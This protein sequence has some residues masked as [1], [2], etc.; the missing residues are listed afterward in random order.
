MPYRTGFLCWVFSL[1]F[2]SSLWGRAEFHLGGP[3]GM[4]WEDLLTPGRE[5]R[6]VV[7]D[8]DGNILE[9]LPLTVIGEQASGSYLSDY[10]YR[11]PDLPSMA[12]NILQPPLIDPE[13]NLARDSLLLARGGHLLT[14]GRAIQNSPPM[15]KMIDGDLT[16]ALLRQVVE[17]PQLAG[18][19]KSNVQAAT[20]NLGAELPINRIR[21][22]PR[23]GFEANY[24]KWY[25][26]GVADND[27]PYREAPFASRPGQVFYKPFTDNRGAN[28]FEPP[29]SVLTILVDEREN[30]D[31]DEDLRFP[32]RDIRFISLRPL[33][34]ERDWEIAE[35]EVY[36][37][38]YMQRTVYRSHIIDF[39]Q[40]VAWSKIRWQGEAPPGTQVLLRTRTGETRQ[41]SLFWEIGVTGQFERTVAKVYEDL[42]DG[43]RFDRVQR[44]HDAENW[45]FWSATYDFAAGLRNPE[46]P[47]EAWADGTLLLSPSPGRYLQFEIV[48][49]ASRDQAPR[50]E[51]LSL[52]LAETPAVEEVIGEI[53]P[54]EVENFGTHA[55][56]YVVKPG[57]RVGNR[58]FD[59][60]EIST[61]GEVEAVHSVRV[62]GEEVIDRFPAEIREDR[63][64]A[65]FA[66][67]EDPSADNEKRIEVDFD[68]RVLSFGAEF[69]GWVYD[70][71]EPEFKQQVKAGNATFRLQGNVL[72]VR[73]PIGGDLLQRMQ[74]R[75]AV[76]TP[77]GDGINDRVAISF[78]LRDLDLP[79]QLEVT[80]FD[81]AGH[82]VREVVSTPSANGSVVQVW[83]GLDGAGTL[84]PPGVYLYQVELDTDEGREAASGVLSVAY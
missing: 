22:Y 66:K 36:G 34:P 28:L 25:E 41:P 32:I 75:P 24:L 7:L 64:I 19:N 61:G 73:T 29:D 46:K 37:E 82:R 30:L 14:G 79:R 84:V 55:F 52:L 76:F 53:W 10:N 70:S 15:Q 80:V 47:S 54:I 8:A 62:G 13:V 12:D 2:S 68:A 17:S 63:I 27:A 26:I 18:F 33:N 38:G 49:L 83:D 1:V 40:R 39:G 21:F 45:S 5:G 74:V 31:V 59:R 57:L 60:L 48:L 81:L 11:P 3:E 16:T 78:D 56:T 9:E 67:L 20:M 35:W 23:P 72:S 51:K 44:T 65:K 71:A 43:A 6:Y 4:L 77:N 50:I 42:F 58:G 69:K